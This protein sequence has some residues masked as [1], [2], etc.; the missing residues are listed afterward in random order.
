MFAESNISD[1]IKR[2]FV[3]LL[4]EKNEYSGRGSG[5]TMESI[6]GLLLSVYKYTPM[7][8]SSYIQLPKF[9][10]WKRATINPQNVDQQCFKWAILAKHVTGAGIFRIGE[11][12]K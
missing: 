4:N 1:I 10:E 7:S 12:Y 5:F 9:I 6:D 8:G 3:N 2:P 11:N